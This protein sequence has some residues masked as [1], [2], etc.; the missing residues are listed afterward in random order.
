M[1]WGPE[2]E[3]QHPRN[4]DSGEWVEKVSARLPGGSV[5]DTFVDPAFQDPGEDAIEQAE[6]WAHR[7]FDYVDRTTGYRSE[8]FDVQHNGDGVIVSA[9]FQDGPR[10]IGGYQ[11]AVFKDE[12][13]HRV[14]TVESVEIDQDQRGQGLAR[15]WVQRM[16]TVFRREGVEFV[17]MWDQS[18]GFWE[19]MGYV[20][21]RF[22]IGGKQL[23]ETTEV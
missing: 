14:G 7:H 23:Q 20:R 16:E 6:Q 15:R 9:T 3:R 12:E 19:H 18:R 8:V 10:S 2:Q 5:F 22:G 21:D 4:P 11:L 1:T 17:S 13:G